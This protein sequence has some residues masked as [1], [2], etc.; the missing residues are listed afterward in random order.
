M[1]DVNSVGCVTG[2]PVTQGGV[3]GRTEATGLGVFYGIRDF[4]TFDSI[5]EQTGLKNGLK[6]TSVIVQGFGNVGFFAAKFISGAG[7]KITA[8]TE[9][10]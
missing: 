4:L 5:K 7:A 3:R 1:N 10:N 2:K 9:Y 8:I 6:G